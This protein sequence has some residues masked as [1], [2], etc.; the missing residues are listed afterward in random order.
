MPNVLWALLVAAALPAAT[1]GVDP[2]ASTIRYSVVHKL[3]RVDAQSHD[4][5]GKAVVKG[6]GT[7]LAMVRVAVASFR[8]GDANRDAHML[9]AVEAGRFPYVVFKGTA[10]LG[11]ARELPSAPLTMA[12]E[13]EL[14]GVKRPV[15]IPLTVVR[16]DDGAIQARGSF[17]VSLDAYGVERPS[18]LFVKIDDACHIDLDLVLRGAP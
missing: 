3:H 17:D 8:S 15:S 4:I 18:L 10:Q 7:E 1:L 13:L 9:E 16:R 14:H 12:G 2:A 5:D 6:D 11:A